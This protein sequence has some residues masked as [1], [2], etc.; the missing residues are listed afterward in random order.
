MNNLTPLLEPESENDAGR[1]VSFEF[2]R[3]EHFDLW[4]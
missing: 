1:R 3:I 2:A 4:Q